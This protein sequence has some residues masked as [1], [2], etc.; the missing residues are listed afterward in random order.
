MPPCG[1]TVRPVAYLLTADVSR[2]DERLVAHRNAVL[3]HIRQHVAGSDSDSTAPD[4][5]VSKK[6][7]RAETDSD[8][9]DAILARAA[10]EVPAPP[11]EP[12]VRYF[13]KQPRKQRRAAARAARAAAAVLQLVKPAEEKNAVADPKPGD[14]AAQRRQ[15]LKDLKDV[16]GKE[17]KKKN[18][19]VCA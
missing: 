10:P 3:E 6:S 8:S 11:A 17:A 12:V 16:L 4:S 9:D 2:L 15:A 5:P 1:C 13:H 18:D 7:M 14:A 19:E